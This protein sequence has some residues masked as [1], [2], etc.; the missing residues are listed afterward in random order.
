[1]MRLYVF[2]EGQTE[3]TFVGT[4]LAP[5]FVPLEVEV[6]P[7]ILPNKPG[8]N[9]RR[10]K[11]GWIDYRKAR[12]FIR[13][14]MQQMHAEDTWFT[15]MLDLYAL[16][17]DFPGMGNAPHG[18]AEA[19]IAALEAAFHADICDDRLWRFTSNLQLH[20]YEA[21][22]LA[23]PEALIHFYPDR[24]DAVAALR[25]DIGGLAPEAVNEGPQTAPSKR[26]IHHLPEYNK[27]VAGTLVAM[28]IG[29]PTLRACCPHF[30]AWL[31]ALERVTDRA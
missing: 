3:E 28:E 9:V 8:S 29:L 27:V 31:V 4:L 1:M 6:T 5:H 7:L 12:R 2:C 26:I 19:R 30:D 10:H 16:P 22:L 23:A 14:V 15:T 25:A 21:L 18:P 13:E 11:G 20:E 24:T 17:A